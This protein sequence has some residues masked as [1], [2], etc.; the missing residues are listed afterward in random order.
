MA[1]FVGGYIKNVNLWGIQV[2]RPDLKQLEYVKPVGT[3]ALKTSESVPAP[4]WTGVREAEYQRTRHL[5]LV[6]V[7]APSAR[8]GQKFDVSIYLMRH[9]RGI[10]ENQTTGFTEV[11]SAEFF[12]G[13]SWGNSV[14]TAKIGEGVI[15][16]TTSAWGT[17]LATC[18]VSFNDGGEPI[19][20]QRYID[21][22]MAPRNQRASEAG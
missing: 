8:V 12:F 10:T 9:H 1:L 5:T 11:Q 15:G 21:Y 18:R 17:F 19:I 6:H 16:I 4:P 2:E 7:Y 13:P 14:F 20:L 22:E 3:R